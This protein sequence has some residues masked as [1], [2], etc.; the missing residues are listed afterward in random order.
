MPEVIK[1]QR[2]RKKGEKIER[3]VGYVMV[4]DKLRI[5]VETDSL[6]IEE[7]IC[8][9]IWG[10]NKYFTSWQGI[11]TYLVR[12]FTTE[13]VAKK[14]MLSLIEARKE[15]I[16]A[17]KE[18]EELLLGNVQSELSNSSLKI[19]ENIKNFDLPEEEINFSNYPAK[20]GINYIMEFMP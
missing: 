8:K 4:N 17:I 18:L 13:K 11:F 16:D 10:N 6:I 3:D 5:R 1:K 2:G 19:A 9:E 14:G 20:R 15:I 12:R 7:L